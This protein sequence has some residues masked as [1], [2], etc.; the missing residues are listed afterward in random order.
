M[1]ESVCLDSEVSRVSQLRKMVIS[2]KSALSR[3]IRALV[4][5][6]FPVFLADTAGAL[7]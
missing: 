2:A 3:F 4:S 5:L 7:S 1:P 6:D